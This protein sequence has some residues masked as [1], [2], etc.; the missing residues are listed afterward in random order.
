MPLE[1][2]GRH[3][4]SAP[5]P[6]APC[7]PLRGSVYLLNPARYATNILSLNQAK[8]LKMDCNELKQAI[9][10]IAGK[11]L[12]QRKRWYSSAAKA[13]SFARPKYPSALVD[14]AIKVAQLS[15]SSRILE[16]GSGPGPATTS[17]AQIGCSMVCIEPN[18]VFCE[19]ARINCQSYPSVNV[20]NKSFKEWS[21]ELEAFDAV[22]AA[23]SMHWIPA[24]IGYVKASGALKQE[25]I[26]TG[27]GQMMLDSGRFRNLV[28]ATKEPVRFTFRIYQRI[29]LHRR[30]RALATSLID[31]VNKD[32]VVGSM[33]AR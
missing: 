8:K 6:W 4:L 18:P 10:G 11:D 30:C 25:D 33:N 15:S 21:P 22:L 24:E 1:W 17:F 16:I 27:L 5:P 26:L 14:E 2:T 20:I 32:S 29:T 9:T 28:T 13:Y 23:S 12:E 7:L 19:L 3:P 31:S